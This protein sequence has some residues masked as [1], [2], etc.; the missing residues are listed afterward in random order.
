MQQ[1]IAECMTDARMAAEKAKRLQTAQTQLN[2]SK[3]ELDALRITPGNEAEIHGKLSCSKYCCVYTV[4]VL[5]TTHVAR[6][7]IYGSCAYSYGLSQLQDP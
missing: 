4:A 5:L 6:I 2:S 3:E 1:A 7:A